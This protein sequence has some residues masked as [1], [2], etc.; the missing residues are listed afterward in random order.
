MGKRWIFR[1]TDLEYSFKGFREISAMDLSARIFR[2]GLFGHGFFGHFVLSFGKCFFFRIT[3]L[4]S[5][6]RGRSTYFGRI[7]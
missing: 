6:I 1:L 4:G 3:G 5:P 2:P 7:S